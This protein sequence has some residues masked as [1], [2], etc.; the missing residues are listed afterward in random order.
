MFITIFPD[1]QSAVGAAIEMQKILLDYNKSLSEER[2]H[3]K[4]RLNGIG[5]ACGTGVILDNEGKLHGTPAIEAYTIGEDIC[6]N[7]IILVTKRV[8]ECIKAENSRYVGVVYASFFP[9]FISQYFYFPCHQF[10]LC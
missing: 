7:G 2:Q 1:S 5:L 10:F 9:Q 6:E 4:V 8:A 3:Y